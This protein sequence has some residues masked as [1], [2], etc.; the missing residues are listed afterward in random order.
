[1]GTHLADPP[2]PLHAFARIWPTPLPLAACVLYQW[3]LTIT[4]VLNA[5]PQNGSLSE[6]ERFSRVDDDVVEVGLPR[7]DLARHVKEEGHDSVG[8]PPLRVG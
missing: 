7:F 1:M 3:P 8:I 4:L 2:P 6:P 5:L